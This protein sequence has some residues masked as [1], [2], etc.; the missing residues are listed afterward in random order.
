MEEALEIFERLGDVKGQTQCFNELVRLFWYQ[1]RIDDAEKAGLR[2][3]D[4][5][6]EK[7]QEPLV[8]GLHQILGRIYRYERE[9]QKAI[10]HF[11]TALRL[12]S[13][14]N[15]RDE[16]FQIHCYLADLF[17][18][19]GEFDDANAHTERANSHAIDYAYK[20]GR[21]MQMQT[22]VRRS[23]SPFASHTLLIQSRTSSQRPKGR[24]DL[25]S[26]LD[27]FIQALSIVKDTCAIPPAQVAFS[28][29][30]ALLAIIRVRFPLV[31]Q[32]RF[33]T[34]AVQYTM[35]ND[36]DYIQLGLACASACQ[37]VHQAL[38][39]VQL[40]EL[41]QPAIDTIR[42]LTT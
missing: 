12:A 40:D 30:S 32:D 22:K 41:G 19:K 21:A 39:R 9:E 4:L 14:Y 28:C 27:V 15:G 26:T 37:V 7:G 2:A 18:N 10:H 36:R 29:S 23:S 1:K 5:L 33:L 11:E 20:R 24:N 8:C 13:T 31:C 3:V 34:Q 25:L 6:S 35:A 17:R 16:P 42:D 38:K